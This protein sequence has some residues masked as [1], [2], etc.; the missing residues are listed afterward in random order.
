MYLGK[1]I[2]IG[3]DVLLKKSILLVLMLGVFVVFT[4][5]SANSEP[6]QESEPIEAGSMAD[7]ALAVV[8]KNNEA[9]NDKDV[10]AFTATYVESM[11]ENAREQMNAVIEGT[12]FEHELSS[13]KVIE[14]SE[15]NVILSV[16]QTTK[17]HTGENDDIVDIIEHELVKEN[18]K[19]KIKLSRPAD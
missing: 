8:E 3:G 12:D 14:A 6:N 17:D 5:C 18:G 9:M 4:A 19:F 2:K 1:S 13:P 16:V 15:N 7:E 11:Q 10:D